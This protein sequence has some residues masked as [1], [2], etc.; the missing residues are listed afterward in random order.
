MHAAKQVS[1]KQ[2]N[3]HEQPFGE[4]SATYER[5]YSGNN[6]SS[7]ITALVHAMPESVLQSLNQGGCSRKSRPLPLLHFNRLTATLQIVQSMLPSILQSILKSCLKAS[8][9]WHY[10]DVGCKAA[11]TL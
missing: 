4:Q 2:S 9:I 8:I 5:A 3:R 10:F 1:L 7:K 11:R 6:I